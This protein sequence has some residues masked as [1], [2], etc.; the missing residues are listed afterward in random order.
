MSRIFSMEYQGIHKDYSVRI[1]LADGWCRKHPEIRPVSLINGDRN[2]QLESS[3]LCVVGHADF[4]SKG[5]RFKSLR[6]HHFID[7]CVMAFHHRLCLSEIWFQARGQTA[8]ISAP[9]TFAGK[10]FHAVLAAHEPCRSGWV[11][12]V[13]GSDFPWPIGGIICVFFPQFDGIL[14]GYRNILVG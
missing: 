8:A 5:G 9:S 14:W 2:W 11:T 3:P 6:L 13:E 1:Y 4:T 12:L 10:A 7:A